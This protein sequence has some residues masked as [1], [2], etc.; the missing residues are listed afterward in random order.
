MLH[1]HQ[2]AHQDRDKLGD[3]YNPADDTTFDKNVYIFEEARVGGPL[4]QLPSPRDPCPRPPRASQFVARNWLRAL[5]ARPNANAREV[6]M[7]ERGC[8]PRSTR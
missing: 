5:Y 3:E 2:H 8:E 4:F 7:N 1:A 6:R